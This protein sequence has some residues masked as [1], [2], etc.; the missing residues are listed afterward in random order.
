MSFDV[1]PSNQVKEVFFSRKLQK[2]TH[3]LLKLINNTVTQSVIFSWYATILNTNDWA[4]ELKCVKLH[5][6]KNHQNLV[7]MLFNNLQKFLVSL[8]Y[9]HLHNGRIHITVHLF[10]APG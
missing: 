10:S 5:C 9:I 2:L 4:E 6:L 3:P 1:D 7:L 8:N